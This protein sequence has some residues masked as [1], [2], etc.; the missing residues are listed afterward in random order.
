MATVCAYQFVL[1]PRE[2][3]SGP[4]CFDAVRDEI[5]DWICEIYRTVGMAGVAIPF[6]GTCLAPHPAHELWSEQHACSTHRLATIEWVWPEGE[7]RTLCWSLACTVACDDKTVQTALL[8]RIVSR[9]FLLRPLRFA[10]KANNPLSFLP[11]LA[12]RLLR[13]WPGEIGGWPIGTQVRQLRANAMDRFVRETLQNPART[14]PVVVINLDGPV[15]LRGTGV[16]GAQDRL[17]GL[18]QLVALANASATRRLAQLLPKD[19]SWENCPARVYWPLLPNESSSGIPPPFKPDELEQQL[20]THSLDQALLTKFIELS[21]GRYREGELIRAAHLAVE[22]EREGWRQVASTAE[23][24]SKAARTEARQAREERDRLRQECDTARQVIRSLQ[25]D[26]STLRDAA[27]EPSVP[28]S[29]DELAA[30]L[31]R[32]WDENRRLTGEIEVERRQLEELRQELHIHQENWTLF[33]AA[34]AADGRMPAPTPTSERTFASV[35]EVVRA[36]AEDFADV[37][38]IWEN[39]QRSAEQ[40]SFRTPSKV[41]RALEAI[42]EVGRVY[43]QARDGGPP[44]GPVEHAF[45]CRVPFKYT[46][47]ESHTT[48]HLH[49]AE[50][51]FHHD[52]QSR[53]MQRHL[54]LGGGETNNCLQIYFDFDDA[55]RRVLI[56]YCGRHLPYYRQRT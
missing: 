46:G 45:A 23:R 44:L 7:D 4:D 27:K 49:G 50:R 35:A 42:A 29:F 15:H 36:A 3:Q 20:Q 25:A 11:G 10:I 41:Y 33:A 55:S 40:S 21:A 6:D 8:I 14:L 30:E 19:A 17:L 43:F 34:R 18:A 56:G 52:N 28:S 47:F 13:L 54:T 37:L 5:A 26:L 48:M 12:A 1:R 22:R 39:A 38:A 24:E 16:Q 32:A 53:Q 2:G 51:V 31:E 9:P